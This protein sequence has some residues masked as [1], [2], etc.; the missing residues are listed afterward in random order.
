LKIFRFFLK[1]LGFFEAIFQPC[2]PPNPRGRLGNCGET[3]W[4][5][6][7]RVVCWSTKATIS[8]RRAKIDK[9]LLWRAYR[10]SPTLFRIIK[11]Y[12]IPDLLRFLFPR[13]GVRNPHPKIQSLLYQEGVK[14]WTSNLASTFIGY[15][16][17]NAQLK[18]LRQLRVCQCGR[19]QGLPNFFGGISP[20]IS[21]TGKGMNFKFCTHIHSINWKKKPIKDFEKSTR[22]RSQGLPKIFR[23]LTYTWLIFVIAQLSQ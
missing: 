7:V 6:T 21:G 1:N 12:H 10:N 8:L 16:R 5:A 23:A 4:G 18:I 20:I 15:I 2:H 13:L 3:R 22:G 9:K 17:T 14:L 19:I 11:L